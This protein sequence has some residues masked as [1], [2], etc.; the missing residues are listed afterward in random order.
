M[1]S[2]L[3]PKKHLTLKILKK[4]KPK[5]LYTLNPVKP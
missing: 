3:N 5:T 4:P 2:T 1:L